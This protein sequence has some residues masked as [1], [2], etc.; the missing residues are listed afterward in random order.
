MELL[1]LLCVYALSY[2]FVYDEH[3][4]FVKDFC[5]S[6]ST[7]C[8]RINPSL[9]EHVFECQPCLS[10]WVSIPFGVSLFGVY[11]L[12]FSFACYGFTSIVSDLTSK[13]SD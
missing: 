1:A 13:D 7:Y 5:I 2:I 3:F 10:F 9:I 6:L 11:F 12:V 8:K 4:F